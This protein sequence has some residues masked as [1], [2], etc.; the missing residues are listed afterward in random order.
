M[1][2]VLPDPIV[3]EKLRGQKVFKDNPYAKYQFEKLAK[4]YSHLQ[5][6]NLRGDKQTVKVERLLPNA[7]VRMGDQWDFK[8]KR[9]GPWGNETTVVAPSVA[10]TDIK[11][12]VE[13][14]K[15]DLSFLQQLYLKQQQ[16]LNKQIKKLKEEYIDKALRDAEAEAIL[17]N[18]RDHERLREQ[19]KPQ[20]TDPTEMVEGV[21][22]KSLTRANKKIKAKKN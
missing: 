17:A 15:E 20:T 5:K 13:G 9:T 8:A 14:K 19:R 4:G 1:T 7:R 22:D 16:K 3:E 6:L 11:P 12:E 2:T 10:I 21:V 18:I